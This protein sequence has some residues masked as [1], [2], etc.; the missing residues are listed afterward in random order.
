MANGLTKKMINLQ[1]ND[2]VQTISSRTGEVIT[3]TVYTFLDRNQAQE[4]QFLKIQYA[5]G[6]L[7]LTPF[8]L[9]YISDTMS[10]GQF[11]QRRAIHAKDVSIGN[12]IFIK[13]NSS[14]IATRI[15]NIS[16]SRSQGYIA[17]VTYSGNII[18]N[19]V[20]ASCYAV[21]GDHDLAHVALSPLRLIS[22]VFGSRLPITDFDGVHWY[23]KILMSIFS[24]VL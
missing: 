9:I 23:A 4:K 10:V 19:G 6:H 21:I 3:D 7:E 16:A 11:Q 18:V 20:A 13:Q 24:F 15:T 1:I 22:S 8:H 14:M 5:G 12:Y 2:Q 17:P